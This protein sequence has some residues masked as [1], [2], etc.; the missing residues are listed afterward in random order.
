[1]LSFSFTAI[2]VGGLLIMGRKATRRSHTL[3]RKVE[4]VGSQGIWKHALR[5][6]KGRLANTFAGQTFL[7]G[8]VI[9][10]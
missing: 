9:N 10:C 6:Q 4:R 7:F 3:R 5:L 2:A 8:W 1:M